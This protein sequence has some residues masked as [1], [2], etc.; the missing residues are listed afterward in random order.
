MNKL[1]W[2]EGMSVGIEAIDN[3]HKKIISIIDAISEAIDNESLAAK[4]L[5]TMQTR[6]YMRP[7]TLDETG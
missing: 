3:D 4:N 7:N 2:N 6:F 5:S 1:L